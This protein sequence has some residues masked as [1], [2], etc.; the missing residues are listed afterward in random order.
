MNESLAL[1]PTTEF[2]MRYDELVIAVGAV[3]NTFG[4]PGNKRIH[5]YRF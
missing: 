4:I 5:S 1:T 3:P 2:T